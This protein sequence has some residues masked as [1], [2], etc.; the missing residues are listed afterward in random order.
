ME[1]DSTFHT[2]L[3]KSLL[4]TMTLE[5]QTS[6]LSAAVTQGTPGVAADSNGQIHGLGDHA[7]NSISMDGQP[8]TDQI[9][10]VFSNQLPLDCGA[11][12]GG[13]FWRAAGGIWREDERGDQCDDAVPGRA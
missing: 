13:N 5:S 2:D 9:S 10:K 7:E 12:D 6:Q 8:M 1:N 11:I 3:D 4:D